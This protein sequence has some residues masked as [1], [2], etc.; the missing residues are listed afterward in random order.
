MEEENQEVKKKNDLPSIAEYITAPD[1]HFRRVKK[2]QQNLID[3]PVGSASASHEKAQL[4]SNKTHYNPYDPD[5]GISVMPGKARKLN[6]HCSMAVDT[7]ECLMYG[8]K[9]LFF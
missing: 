2:H 7:T 3:N 6:Y 8:E 4:L 1:H 5:A 9:K